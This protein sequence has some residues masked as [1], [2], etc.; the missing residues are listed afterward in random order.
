MVTGKNPGKIGIFGFLKMNEDGAT[1]VVDSSCQDAES[2]WDILGEFGLCVGVLN[3][4]ATYPPSIVNGFMVTGLLTPTG[5]DYTYPS[6]LAQELDRVVDGYLIEPIVSHS[7][8]REDRKQAFLSELETACNKRT[9]AAK[10]LMNK[11]PWD[12]FMLV[13]RATDLAQHYFLGDNLVKECYMM[14]DRAVGEL[15]A[16]LRQEDHLMIVS[17][18]GT[19][20]LHLTFYVNEWLMRQRLLKLKHQHPGHRGALFGRLRKAIIAHIPARI[21]HLLVDVMPDEFVKRFAMIGIIRDSAED[22][23][24]AIDWAGTIAYSLPGFHGIFV[25]RRH[26]SV[27]SQPE[28]DEVRDNIID[29][30]R[31][32]EQ[33]EG[34]DLRFHVWR[35]EEIYHGRHTRS[36]PDIVLGLP[37]AR[38]QRDDTW[39]TINVSSFFDVDFDGIK[40]KGSFWGGPPTPGGHRADGIWMMKGPGVKN[41]NVDA[42]MVD[43]HPTILRIFDIP[44]PNDLDGAVLQVFKNDSKGYRTRTTKHRYARKPTQNA[45][46]SVAEEERIVERLKKLGYLG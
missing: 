10:Y 17:D 9:R 45:T 8:M 4:P 29:R 15:S 28:Y 11:Y 35:R 23:R 13:Y 18:H 33:F 32:I 44:A 1:S 5:K 43:I 31:S 21:I 2:I 34:F 36:A 41:I 16:L 20:P 38:R 26:E 40:I 14:I 19:A 22:L 37:E 39:G 12:F 24:N 42:N 27:R 3:V 25:N 7:Q 46:L 6:E 30:L